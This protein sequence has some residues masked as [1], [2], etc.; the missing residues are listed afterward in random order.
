MGRHR[1][2]TSGNSFL[3][4]HGCRLFHASKLTELSCYCNPFYF[5]GQHGVGMTAVETP[6]LAV[7]RDQDA[8]AGLLRE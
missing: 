1:F 7:N 6:E 3:D 2:I 8:V 5:G 4:L